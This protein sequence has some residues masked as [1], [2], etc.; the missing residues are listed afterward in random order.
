MLPK[1]RPTAPPKRPM[2]NPALPSKV[3]RFRV[4]KPSPW[5][6]LPGDD[7]PL[8][9]LASNSTSCQVISNPA[10]NSSTPSGTRSLPNP[11]INA[12]MKAGTP[13]TRT[14]RLDTRPSRQWRTEPAIALRALTKMLMPAAVGA[15]IPMRS[16]AGRRTV[17]KARPT[18]APRTPT[19]VETTVNIIACQRAISPPKQISKTGTSIYNARPSRAKWQPI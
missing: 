13:I 12:P 2:E 3:F 15:Y 10:K 9:N 17:P 19:A 14:I 18:N 5:F 16:S 11:P 1:I 6:Y 8:R 4:N 7:E